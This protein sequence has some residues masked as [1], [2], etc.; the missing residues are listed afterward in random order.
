MSRSV[1]RSS[2]M[3]LRL[4]CTPSSSALSAR[5][6]RAEAS[7]SAPLDAR[8]GPGHVHLGR[9]EDAAEFVVDV[10]RELRLLLLAHE[11]QVVRQLDQLGRPLLDLELEPGPVFGQ[12]GTPRLVRGLVAPHQD[13]H[14]RGE[15]DG[16]RRHQQHADAG[17]ED[18]GV[19]ARAGAVDGLAMG[20]RQVGHFLADLVHR[21]LADAGV[22]QRLR[23]RR[24]LLVVEGDR[25]F[26]LRQLLAD[27]VVEAVRDLAL[28]DG[29]VGDEQLRQLG[30]RRVDL[31]DGR[32]VGLEVLAA[33]GQHVAALAGLGADHQ[34]L[35]R[36][37]RGLQLERDRELPVGA[38][39][40]AVAVLR[41]GGDAE[42]Q[43]DARREDQRDERGNAQQGEDSLHGDRRHS[44]LRRPATRDRP[45]YGPAQA[46]STA[47]PA[48]PSGDFRKRAG[49]ALARNLGGFRVDRVG[50]ERTAFVFPVSR[51]SGEGRARGASRRGGRSSGSRPRRRT[52]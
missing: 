52:R 36:E 40:A 45:L 9:D 8:L 12:R 47:H 1:G 22:H 7:A 50:G 33:A 14:H 32:V 18:V 28:A 39:E 29:A 5:S 31:R 20:L 43:D 16:E 17:E 42:R 34:G 26:Q 38:F 10:A 13:P 44:G 41:V 2:S 35:R 21:A 3:I 4:I 30:H 27:E 48:G 25:G 6:S 19:P 15:R 46:R 11:L 49:Q 37:Q 51:P 23:G 24:P